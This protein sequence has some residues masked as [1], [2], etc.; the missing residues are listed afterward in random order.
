MNF[1]ENAASEIGVADEIELY[2]IENRSGTRLIVSNCGAAVVSLFVKDRQGVFSDIVLGYEEPAEYLRDQ[3]YLGAVVGRY[4]NRIAGDTV[5]INNRSYKLPVKPGGYHL[6]GGVE[7]FNKK[8]FEAI[9][10]QNGSN[11]G[12]VFKYTSPHLEEGFPGEL[13]LEVI[14]TLDEQDIWTIEYKCT[15]NQTT[16]VNLTQHTYFNLS[17]HFAGNIDDHELKIFSQYYLPVNKMQVPTG[18]FMK[19]D[20][21]PFDFTEF[22]KIGQDIDVADDQ[23]LL[24]NGYDHSLVLE[25]IHTPVLKQSAIVKEPLTGRK[26]ELF[27]TEPAVHFYSG[28]FLQNVKGKNGTLYNKR[29]GFCLETQHFP[30]APN[31]PHFPSTVLNAGDEFYSKTIFKFSAE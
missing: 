25:R 27:T 13:H 20:N 23:L 16:L 30:D 9:P 5:V 11:S 3:Y 17:G 2:T 7:G 28:N 12:I 4:A 31:H 26:I 15:C 18:E 6:H 24:S 8:I 21:T 19:V 22:K 10:F 14:Y 1:T 29:S